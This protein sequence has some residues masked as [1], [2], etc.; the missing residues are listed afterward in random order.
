ME[1]DLSFKN[2]RSTSTYYIGELQD[3]NTKLTPPR[4]LTF[5]EGWNAPTAWTSDS[6]AVIFGSDRNGHWGIYKQ[7]LNRDSAETLVTSDAAHGRPYQPGWQMDSLLHPADRDANSPGSSSPT[8]LRLMRIP[9]TGGPPELVLTARLY[10]SL[11]RPLS[12]NTVRF[13]RADT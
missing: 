5:S 2:R 10:N 8:P 9:V 11:V 3:R 13:C 6:K 7:E 4:K 12:F 1:S